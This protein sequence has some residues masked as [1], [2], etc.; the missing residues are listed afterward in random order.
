MN[1]KAI[2]SFL[3]GF[4]IL[5]SIYHFPEFFN[6][7]WIM[8]VCKVGF[9]LIAFLLALMQGWKGLGGFGLSLKSA[10][11]YN[12]IKGL[13]IG[14]LG[15]GFSVL[16]SVGLGYERV[17]VYPTIQT[18]IKQLPTLLLMT[19]IP[20]IAEDILTRGYL[21]GHLGSKMKK[22]YWIFLSAIVFVLNHIWRLNDGAA[23]L[24]Y[25]FLLGL[26]LAYTVWN[27]KSLWL[28]F[29][30]HWGSNIAY[31]STNSLLNIESL[32]SHKGSTW[33]LAIIWGVILLIFLFFNRN[34][35]LKRTVS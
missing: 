5:F 35:N 4:V 33:V 29:G 21:F 19:S 25:L 18:L 31:E 32:V 3:T 24:T 7:F 10:W 34:I 14:L 8:A 27:T 6:A 15:F 12:L 17:A 13:S 22:E 2:L 26:L 11:G 30:I 28:A 1:K 16:C 23:V 20:S 9:L